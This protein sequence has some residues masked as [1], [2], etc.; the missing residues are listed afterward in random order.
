LPALDLSLPAAHFE[1]QRPLVSL[2]DPIVGATKP[3]I[4]VAGVNVTLPGD[5]EGRRQ[6]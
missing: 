4:G 1:W 3:I 2:H 5:N 6:R